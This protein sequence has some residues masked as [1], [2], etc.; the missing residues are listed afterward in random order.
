MAKSIRLGIIGAGSAQFSIGLVRDLCLTENLVGS[1]VCLMDIDEE[2][3]N[4][5]HNLATRYAQELGIELKF[6]RTAKREEALRNTDFVLNT[7]SVGAHGGGGYAS[8]HNLRF[9]LSVAR[10]MERF[11]PDAWL[12]QSGNPVFEGCTLMTRETDIKVLGLCHGHYGV[13]AMTRVLGLENEYV[14]WQAPGLNHVIYLTHFYYKG[15]NAYPILDEW[16]ETRAEEYWRTYKPS[17]SENQMSRAAIQ[18]YKMIGLMPIGD[19]PRAGGWW[20]H[21]SQ[22]TKRQWYG[23]IGGFDSTE[24]WAMYIE[25]LEKRRAEMFRVAGDK[26]ASVTEV[27]PPNKSREQIVP[28]IDALVNDNSDYFQVNIPNNGLITG[29]P[30]DVVVEVPAFVSKCGIQGIQIG[31]LPD[32]L[33]LQIILP[34]LVQA[35]RRIGL[36]KSPN[37]GLLLNMILYDHVNLSNR[38]TPP[39]ASFEDAEKR[40]SRIL[41]DDPEL[42]KLIGN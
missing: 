29:I 24:G 15:E 37:K 13:Y 25:G 27:F 39:V 42:A 40:M 32:N 21:T 18:Q 7:A 17:F 5:V 31:R 30:D 6:E 20:F 11:C 35:E 23:P 28:I 34:R 14:T 26:S 19:T 2:R 12:I 38:Y 22:E 16:I 36:A 3:V 4:M 10:D 8:I 41:A 33:M 9:F 1:T